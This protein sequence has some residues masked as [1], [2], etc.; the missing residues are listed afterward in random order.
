MIINIDLILNGVSH[1]CGHCKKLAP[2]YSRAAKQLKLL[3]P[4]VPLAKV[5]ATVE[6]SLAS[7]YGATGYP[8]LIM[9]RRGKRYE[10]KGGR[11]ERSE[12]HLLFRRV[13]F[14]TRST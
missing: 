1:R 3:D 14:V 2:E 7:E 6:S 11:D 10:Y 5:D 13:L 12:S 4:P 8:T 9:F